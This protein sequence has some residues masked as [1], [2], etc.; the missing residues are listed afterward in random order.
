MLRR[1]MVW[2]TLC[3]GGTYTHT[4]ELLAFCDIPF[5]AQKTFITDEEEMDS[6]L[7]AAKDASLKKA[8]EEEK[9]ACLAELQAQGKDLMKMSQ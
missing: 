4:K 5:M 1:A 8:V 9:S 7:E 3:S 2:G 6:I